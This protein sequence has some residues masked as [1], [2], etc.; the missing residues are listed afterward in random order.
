[1][2]LDKI[3]DFFDSRDTE[4]IAE[5]KAVNLEL[6]ELKSS[7]A[8]TLVIPTPLQS[9]A[10]FTTNISSLANSESRTSRKVSTTINFYE[11]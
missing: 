8:R 5:M 10:I 4:H 11:F 3:L 6:Q 7:I 1:M 2:N 9:S